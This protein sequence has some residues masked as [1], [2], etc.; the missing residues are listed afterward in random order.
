MERRPLNTEEKEMVRT[1][2]RLETDYLSKQVLQSIL[3][4]G[5]IAYLRR[6]DF[7]WVIVVSYCAG[8]CVVTSGVCKKSVNDKDDPAYA[9]ALALWRALSDTE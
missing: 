3:E 8:M 4:N 1:A 2:M 5:E 7:T 9:E 6:S